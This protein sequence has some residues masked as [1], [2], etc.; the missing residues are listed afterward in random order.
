R[1]G[2]NNGE[3]ISGRRSTNGAHWC[4]SVG[5]WIV[6]SAIIIVVARYGVE[7]T[8]D[9]H[10]L[11]GPD[12]LRHQ[13]EHPVRGRT[14]HADRPPRVSGRVVSTA[15]CVGISKREVSST[16]AAPHDHLAAGPNVKS[17]HSEIHACYW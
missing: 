1:P 7:A 4:P 2:P 5:R 14:D 17:Q 8:P 6:S 3:A 16:P 9:D 11:A 13:T 12:R 15:G 10:L